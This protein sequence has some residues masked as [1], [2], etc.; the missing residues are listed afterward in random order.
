MGSYLN[1]IK[2]RRYSLPTTSSSS[3]KNY[4]AVVL[5]GASG[6]RKS[7][8]WRSH[9]EAWRYHR[10]Q[11]V[12]RKRGTESS[13][14]SGQRADPS[15]PSW[16]SITSTTSLPFPSSA[17]QS[18]PR[19]ARIPTSPTPRLIFFSSIP[20]LSRE[21]VSDYEFSKMW[22]IKRKFICVVITMN[23]SY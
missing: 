21:F 7:K 15:Q 16:T 1:Y 4:K 9:F 22:L 13:I 2:R 10:T 18:P 5:A 8:K 19:F 23:L 6:L 17:P 3:I 14:S 12:W 11:R 20:D